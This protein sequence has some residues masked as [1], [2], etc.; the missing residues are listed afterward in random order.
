M[1]KRLVALPAVFA[2]LFAFCTAFAAEAQIIAIHNHLDIEIFEIYMSDSSV[3]NWEEDILG[4]GILE[5]GETLNVT[6]LGSF[7]Q[8]DVL[9]IDR[10]GNEMTRF[11][12]PGNTTDILVTRDGLTLGGA[13][14]D[15]EIRAMYQKAREAY[16]EWFAMGTLP[17]TGQGVDVPG[18]RWPYWRVAHDRISSM[19]DLRA[20][21]NSLFTE[22]VV[23][24]LISNSS[25][26]D[27][28]GV[29][30]VM[31]ADGGGD[32][33]KGAEVHEI[34]RISDTE[35]V[36]RV[37]VDILEFIYEKM[38]YGDNVVDVEIHNFRLVFENGKWLFSNFGSI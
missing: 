21:L 8:F 14:S 20:Y 28:N 37:S 9:V 18:E 7:D 10:N 16:D 5:A 1:K 23:A 29:L 12:F 31:P 3:D 6:I 11:N 22:D 32:R 4:D 25:Y 15:I 17:T 34:I 35:I 38:E 2:L 30:H 19:A 36:Y 24:K 33:S 27:V 26:R 13:P